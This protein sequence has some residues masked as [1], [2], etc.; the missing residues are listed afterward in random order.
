MTNKILP[1]GKKEIKI[2]YEGG[3]KLGEIKKHLI[4]FIKEGKSA[5][6]VEDL[7]T[8]L[9]REAGGKPSFK[10]V[11][12]YKWAT[13]INLNEGVVHG[14]PKRAIVFKKGDVVSVDIGMYY[15][16]F[17]T[18]TSFTIA[19]KPSW[20]IKEFLKV[21]KEALDKAIKKVIPGNRIYDISKVIEDTLK[22]QG[23]SPIKSLVGHGIGRNLHEDPQI[24]CFTNGKRKDSIRIPQGA[25]LA[26]EVMYTTGKPDIKVSKDGWTI[27]TQSGKIAALF[28]ETVAVTAGGPLVLTKA[29]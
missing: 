17:H 15:Q 20:E 11:D 28:E 8:K 12:G 3:K 18:D 10:M 6:E 24:P 16:G 14:I 13:C 26:I 29:N 2:M 25:T 23:L 19:I 27:V 22:A 7:A 9:I 21:G 4:S 1:K 5:R